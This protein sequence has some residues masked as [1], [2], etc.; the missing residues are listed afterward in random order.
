MAQ[1]S[2][3]KKEREVCTTTLVIFLLGL[4]KNHLGNKILNRSE[5]WDNFFFISKMCTVTAVKCQLPNLEL[6]SYSNCWSHFAI[7]RSHFTI[8]RH[9]LPMKSKQ[10]TM[11]AMQFKFKQWRES[12]MWPRASK[13]WPGVGVWRCFQCSKAI[14]SWLY[15]KKLK[16]HILSNKCKEL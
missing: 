16:S 3:I 10:A 5:I 12:I 8:S 1:N 15:G 4:T 9:F 2:F 14:F 13:M 7:S 6:M 11:T